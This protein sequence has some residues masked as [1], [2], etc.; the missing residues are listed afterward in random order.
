MAAPKRQKPIIRTSVR[1]KEVDGVTYYSIGEAA[2]VIGRTI[3]T[4][5]H[6]YKWEKTNGLDVLP[7][8]H[9]FDERRIRYIKKEEIVDLIRFR[10]SVRYGDMSEYNRKNVWGKRGE[11]IQKRAEEKE[12]AEN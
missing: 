1:I 8:V 12:A 7:D 4:V 11:E 6:W 9:T 5:N 3:G 2:R 10:D